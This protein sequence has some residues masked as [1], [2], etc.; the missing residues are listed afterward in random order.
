MH[1]PGG[2]TFIFQTVGYGDLFARALLGLHRIV[3]L[4]AKSEWIISG[5]LYHVKPILVLR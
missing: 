2:C 4:I 3:C 1:G 5:G